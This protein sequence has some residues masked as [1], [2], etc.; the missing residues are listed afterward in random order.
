MEFIARQKNIRVAP[1]KL[2]LLADLIRGK[3]VQMAIDDMNVSSKR[4][5]K[6][7]S[8]IVKSALNNASQNRGVNVDNLYVKR[9]FVDKGPTMKRFMTRARGGAATILK[10]MAHLTVILDERQK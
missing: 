1:R 7:V 9:V 10:R 2:R 4:W 5:S 6:Q 8:K 3:G